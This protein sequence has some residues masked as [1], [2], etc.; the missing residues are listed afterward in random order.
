M[1]EEQGRFGIEDLDRNFGDHFP[2][3][4][5]VEIRG[6]PGCG[7]TALGLGF[8]SKGIQQ[9]MPGLFVKFSSVP[10]LPVF[11]EFRNN[12]LMADLME[13]E[14]PLVLDVKD[15]H[16]M[17]LLS[18]LMASGEVQNLV[19]DHPDIMQLREK[20]G[21]F[22]SLDDTLD[23]ARDSGSRVLMLDY[24][25]SLGQF[26]AEGILEISFSGDGTRTMEAV[27][28][29]WK[30]AVAGMKVKETEVGYWGI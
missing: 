13:Y 2:K 12:P 10:L 28:W 22:S 14:E 26:M 19:L 6:P 5:V 8:L 25:G 27:K 18:P 1:K 29:E 7:K 30:R 3:G 23:A 17:D 9:G 4:G 24:P 15:P 11:R 21:W 20:E 16:R